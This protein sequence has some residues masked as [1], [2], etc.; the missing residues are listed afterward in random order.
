LSASASAAAEGSPSLA[1]GAPRNSD[2]AE[3]LRRAL[4][5]KLP[6]AAFSSLAKPLLLL[7]LL[8][9][10]AVTAALAST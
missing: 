10:S 4:G 5:R 6:P 8:V 2:A 1:G 7:L 3:R 9:G